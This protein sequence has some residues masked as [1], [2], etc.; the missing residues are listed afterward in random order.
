MLHDLMAAPRDLRRTFLHTLSTG[1][2]SNLFSEA[3]RE[4][5][6]M[7]G[8]W[9]DAPLGFVEDVLGETMWGLQ[10]EVMDAVAIDG[11]NRIAVPAGFG[12]GKTYLAGRLTAWAGAVHPIGEMKIVTTATR[13]R[14]VRSQLWPHIKTAVA[15]GLIHGGSTDT[16]QWI[17]Y[18]LYGNR[19]EIAYGFTAPAN[20]EAA[21]QGIH[22][23]PHL[24]LIVDEA[25]GIAP[26]IGRGTNNL[27]TGHA[28]LLAIGNPAMNEP[29]SWFEGLSRA[30]ADPDEPETIRIHISTLHSPAITGEP[31][32]ICKACAV[33]HDG[34]T[35]SEGVNGKSHLPDW[36]WLRNTLAEYGVIIDREERDLELVKALIWESGQPYLIA[37]VLAEFPT[38]SSNQVI[39]SGWVEAAT[40]YEVGDD[41]K[42]E[43]AEFEIDPDLLSNYV[44]LCDLG[45]PGETEPHW[46]ERG[47]WV[48]L[49]VDVAADG[50]DEF[51]IYRV[52]GDMLHHRHTSA[53]SVNADPMAVAEKILEEIHAAQRLADTLGS[54]AQVRV[55]ID[56]NG[57]G[58]GVYGILQRW[59]EGDESRGIPPLHKAVVVGVMVS[60][61]PFKDDP[62]SVMRP[63]R[64]RD[65]LWLTGRFFVQPDPS[66]GRG[67]LRLR[68]DDKCRVQLSAPKLGHNSS[69]FVVVESKDA[70]KKRG[71]HSPDRAE[72]ALLALYEPEPVG[73]RRRLG[74]LGGG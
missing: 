55:K 30:G 46:V 65:E 45:L 42:T 15:K 62:N 72:A 10:A 17:G 67:R 20:D 2:R 12:V 4:L 24:L 36:E 71:I 38:S 64:K 70:M 39:P 21:M 37:K 66:T 58:W 13:W 8:L 68:V 59:A 49:G 35:I 47:S 41:R 60:E 53:G 3:H 28:K 14:Q 73:A 32:P 11:V 61:S 43:R 63:Y 54:T 51:A 69:G 6:S 48:R 34:H 52:V 7:Y 1:D 29:G 5:G 33:N 27:L 40:T 22:G 19:R 9:H 44:R 23:D 57:L 26:M 16:T 31:T 25:G 56:K 18:D 74:I 50:G